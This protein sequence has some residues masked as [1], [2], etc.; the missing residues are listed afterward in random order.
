MM[1]ILYW[2]PEFYPEIGGI[3]ELS[4]RFL[5]VF[6][7]L[8]YEF[9]VVAA[10]GRQRLPDV[11]SFN[12]IPVH[13]FQ[14]REALGK[15]D[16]GAILAH[17]QRIVQLKQSFNPHLVHLHFGDPYGY[18]HVTTSSAHPAPSLVTLHS[19]VDYPVRHDTLIGRLISQASWV[20]GVSKASLAEPRRAM[21]SIIDR[22]S[23]IYNGLDLPAP[24]PEP[25]DFRQPRI[26]CLGR[27]VKDKGFDLAVAAFAA[28]RQ[29][30]PTSRLIIAGDGLAR[31]AL[32]RQVRALDLTETVEFLGWVDPD[33]VPGLINTATVVVVP[34]RFQE[35]FPLV[36]LQAAQMARPVVA[37]RTGGL[38][39]SVAHGETGLV[40]DRE[41]PHQL[42]D[43]VNFLLAHPEVAAAYG[44]AARARVQAVFSPTRYVAAYDS[45]YKRLGSGIAASAPSPTRGLEGGPAGGEAADEGAGG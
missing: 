11:T 15:R 8:D 7:K 42:A 41:D 17:Q 19:I 39:E 40:V 22:S 23:V 32:E 44:Q 18:F 12:G 27:V 26:L 33:R 38:P 36:A 24:A 28:V 5:P 1:R 34:S 13:R 29:K 9:L 37:T 30:F 35:P 21:P 45:L 10:H 4:R 31:P 6:Q 20:V 43:A 2:T 3:E 16:C 14:F 25:L